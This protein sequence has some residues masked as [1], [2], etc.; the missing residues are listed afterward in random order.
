MLIAARSSQDFA[1]CSRATASARSK[2]A[3]AFA[4]SGCGD[5]SAISPA[6][7]LNLGFAPLLLGRFHRG[8]RFA[9]A[10]PSVVELAEVP[11]RPSPNLINTRAPPCC[12]PLTE[13][14]DAGGDQGGPRPRPCRSRYNTQPSSQHSM[15][16]PEQGAFFIRQSDK[17]IGFAR[18]PP[19]S[20]RSDIDRRLR[21][22]SAYIKV[23]AWPISRASLTA[24]STSTSA[25]SG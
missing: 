5:L 4:V 12:S 24:W 2:Y 7:R 15:R 1:C 21:G 19:H 25:A 13:C 14:N 16:L 17:L 10:A 22:H 6:A 9:D 20:F 23:T 8:H 11:H 18:L 3:S